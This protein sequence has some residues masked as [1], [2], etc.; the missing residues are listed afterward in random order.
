[1][2]SPFSKPVMPAISNVSTTGLPGTAPAA[3]GPIAPNQP[4]KPP[5]PVAPVV[6]APVGMPSEADVRANLAKAGYPTNPNITQN[7]TTTGNTE[8]QQQQQQPQTPAA[9][10]TSTAVSEAEK[11]YKESLGISADETKTQEEID[12]LAE[13]ARLGYQGTKGQAI[14]LQFI[15]GQLK[16]QEERAT[17][18]M[19]PLER[20]LAR[21]Q[22]ARTSSLNA[23]K[24]SLERAD[25]AAEAAKPTT[26]TVAPG[27]TMVRY[28]PATGK[29]ETVFSAPKERKTSTV[30]AG[31]RT[32][33]IDD[34]TGEVIKD[35]GYAGT[36]DPSASTTGAASELKGN[37]LKAAT[38]LLTRFTAGKGTSAVGKSNLF[39]SLGYGLLPGT[40][41]ADFVKTYDNLKSI[42][43]LDNVSLLKGQGAITENER[44]LLA[45]ASTKLDRNLSETEF[46][47]VL[48]EVV[49][50]LGDKVR[51]GTGAA[52]SD[53]PDGEIE[54]ID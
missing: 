50:I 31:G 39:G 49:R 54:I 52:V 14:P 28:N 24:F 48:E 32:L 9:T 10:P 22:A 40:D 6:S 20:K 36:K 51:G 23:S 43:S 26:S 33:V 3:V 45:D 42:L 16:S 30:T 29:T 53:S 46:K 12:L 37:A 18:L 11:A 17:G 25:K 13:A 34:S 38:D 2:A 8:T 1:M 35:L 5:T 41:R 19:E 47:T 44:K 21:M 4:V 7:T 15:T 27:Q